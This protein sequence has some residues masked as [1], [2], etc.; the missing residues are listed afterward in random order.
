VTTVPA[1]IAALVTGLDAAL[2]ADVLDGPAPQFPKGDMLVIGYGNRGSVNHRLD[3]S[4]NLGSK[5]NESYDLVCAASSQDDDPTS[6]AARR[7]SVATM[8]DAARAFLDAD[9]TIGGRCM[10]ALITGSLVWN[11]VIANGGA[12]CYVEFT[13]SVKATI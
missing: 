13:I 12:A 6:M 3:I 8:L 11:Q 5:Y 9:R 10:Q 4:K 7:T 1:V 2:T